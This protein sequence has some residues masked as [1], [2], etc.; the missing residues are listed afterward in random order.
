MYLALD[1]YLHP[2][3][4]FFFKTAR[5][6]HFVLSHVLRRTRRSAISGGRAIDR[7]KSDLVAGLKEE[8]DLFAAVAAILQP[9]PQSN[10]DLFVA[11]MQLEK[12]G[13]LRKK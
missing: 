5:G 6:K 8:E 7:E 2:D 11:R 3:R 12:S 13:G 9:T 10:P 4:V 1:A